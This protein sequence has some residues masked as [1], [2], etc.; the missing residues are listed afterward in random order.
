MLPLTFVEE[1]REVVLR[2]VHGGK[3]MAKKLTEMGLVPGTRVKIVRNQRCGPLV[4]RVKDSDL[5]IGWRIA[6]RIYVE[7]DG[8]G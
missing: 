3:G 1:G 2:A 4:I 8:N 7:V 5:A 6:T